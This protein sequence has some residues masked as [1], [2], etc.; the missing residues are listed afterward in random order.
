MPI[1]NAAFYEEPLNN[2]RQNGITIERV[3]SGIVENLGR[4][5]YLNNNNSRAIIGE[6]TKIGSISGKLHRSTIALMNPLENAANVPNFDELKD[7][8][9]QFNEL[10]NEVCTSELVNTL[11]V[12]LPRVHFLSNQD[13]EVFKSTFTQVGEIYTNRIDELDEKVETVT[14]VASR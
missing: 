12:Y 13:I 14:N 5:S 7:V 3:T 8:A 6:I 4:L 11:F 9:S 1:Q 10:L 2:I